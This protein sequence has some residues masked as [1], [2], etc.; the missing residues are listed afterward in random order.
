MKIGDLVK[1]KAHCIPP[2]I[3]TPARDRVYLVSQD[4]GGFIRL[5]GLIGLT[6]KANFDLVRSINENR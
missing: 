5:H 1:Y 6:A 4:C 3:P 2:T